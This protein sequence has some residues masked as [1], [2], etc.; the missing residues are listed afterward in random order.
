MLKKKQQKWY[1]QGIKICVI[2]KVFFNMTRKIQRKF[3]LFKAIITI[4][5]VI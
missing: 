2:F 1:Y 5:K 3:N 4:F